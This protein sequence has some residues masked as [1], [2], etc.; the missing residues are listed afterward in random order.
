[1]PSVARPTKAVAIRFAKKWA[2]IY[3]Q[4]FSELKQEGG[5]VKLESPFSAFRQKIA[6][7]VTLYDDE[8]KIAGVMMKALLGEEGLREFSLESANWSEEELSEFTNHCATEEAETEIFDLLNLPDSENEW[9]KRRELFNSL[10]DEE[11]VEATTRDIC[12][13]AGV[14]C[15][16]FNVLALMTHGAK[17]TTLVP[18]ALAG[19]DEAFCK[20]VQV[21]R[22]L[23][24]H[25]PYFVERKR[26]AQD[27]GEIEFLRKLA[28]RERNPN[29]QGRFQYSALFMLFGILES[30]QWLEDLKH[31]EILDLFDAAG[32]DRFQNHIQ[33][34]NYV[35]KRLANYRRLQKTGGVSM[36]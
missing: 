28:S 31:D 6:A 18:Q 7:Y 5:R 27:D 10:S 3:A 23:L 13:F 12:L 19:D 8:R 36:H 22:Y 24:S 1:M 11:K 26:K 16:I 20:A 2:P 29:L 32:L 17:L 15:Q 34:V 25:H 21:D 35:T 4:L 9:E 33:D 14:F 30:L